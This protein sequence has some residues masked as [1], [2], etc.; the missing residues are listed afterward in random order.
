MNNAH[1]IIALILAAIIA[2]I[3]FAFVR[4]NFL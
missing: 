4:Q 3:V 1:I 2:F